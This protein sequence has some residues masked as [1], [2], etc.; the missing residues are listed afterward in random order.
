MQRNKTKRWLK[1]KSRLNPSV[2]NE[3]KEK[4]PLHWIGKR[5]W[6]GNN[7][8]PLKRLPRIALMV[9]KMEFLLFKKQEALFLRAP[10]AMQCFFFNR[11]F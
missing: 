7:S 1:K 11:V 9:V 2:R 6:D 8:P 4:T 5:E 10:E 3:M